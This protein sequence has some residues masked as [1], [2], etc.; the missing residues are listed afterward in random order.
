[1]FRTSLNWLNRLGNWTSWFI[2]FSF[3]KQQL[4]LCIELDEQFPDYQLNV[5]KCM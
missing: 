2:R 4:G 5:G 1:M 3:P